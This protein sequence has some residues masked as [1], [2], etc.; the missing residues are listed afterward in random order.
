VL[1]KKIYFS[2]KDKNKYGPDQIL[3]NYFLYKRGFV[4][5]DHTYNFVF[6]VED[7]NFKIKKGVFYFEDGKK[8]AVPHNAG[9]TGIAR[10]ISKFGFGPRYNKLRRLHYY[11]LRIGLKFK[12]LHQ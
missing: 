2:I 10:F 3:I 9:G 4:E 11:S 5:L 8:I 1:S 12:K 6:L 7:T